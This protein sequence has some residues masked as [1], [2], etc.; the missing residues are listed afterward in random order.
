MDGVPELTQ[1]VV[2]PDA[3]F[4]Y[5]FA[6][7][8]AGTYWYH[9]H[10]RTFEQ[11]ARGLAGTLIVDE[12]EQAPAVDPDEVFLIDS[13][14]LT[15]DARIAERFGNMQDVAHAGRIGNW[16]TVN[17]R[18][19]ISRPVA[20]HNRMRLRLINTANARVFTVEALGPDGWI[21][22]LDDM[23]LNKPLPLA[24]LR[25]ALAQRA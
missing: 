23:P 4:F 6:V 14:R 1:Q 20:L 22:A 7:P 21:I 5:A 25:L 19:S 12:A 2:Q 8:D 17:G 15:E 10:N 9:L 13:R 18:A 11:L 24:N 3:E 16:I